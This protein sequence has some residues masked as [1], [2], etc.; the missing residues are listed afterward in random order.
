MPACPD[1]R[2]QQIAVD[3]LAAILVCGGKRETARD[4]DIH[5]LW[6]MSLQVGKEN[7]RM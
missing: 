1:R 2:W 6:E 5:K 4:R 7:V 3:D